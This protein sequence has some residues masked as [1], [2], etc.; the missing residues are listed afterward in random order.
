MNQHFL[1]I[2]QR[3]F[4]QHCRHPRRHSYQHLR[5]R[6]S[7]GVRDSKPSPQ[8][9]H[10]Q[11]SYVAIA[12]LTI[13]GVVGQILCPSD[14]ALATSCDDV[15]FIF[16]RGSG[17]ALSDVS[18]NAWHSALERQVSRLALKYSF[19]ELGSSAHGGYQYP[20]VSVSN[21]LGGIMTLAGAYVS[22]GSAFDFGA[23]VDQG[24]NELKSYLTEVSRACPTTKFVLGGY[25]QGAMLISRSLAELD[26]ERIIYVATFGDPKIYLPE[27]EAFTY[28]VVPKVPDACYG[29]NLSPYRAHVPD[30]Y[31]Y[32]GVLGSYRPYQPA[33]YAGK[34]GTWCNDKD[35]MCSS[36]VSLSDH[37]SY[38]ATDLYSSAAHTIAQKLRRAFGLTSTPA[39]TARPQHDIAILIDSTGSMSSYIEHYKSEAKRLATRV[40]NEGGR[41]ALFEYRDLS[42]G[43]PTRQLCDFSCDLKTLSTKLDQIT[44]SGGGDQPESVL[45]AV[46]T[47]LDSLDWLSGATKSIIILTDAGYHNPDH[48]GRTLDEV[49]DYSLSIDPV[50]VYV[51]TSATQAI[52]YQELVERTNGRT[53]DI[54]EELTL[55]TDTILG[56][57]YAKLA[58][59]EYYGAPD[60]EFIFDASGSYA[61]DDSELRFDWDLDGDGIFE[62]EDQP[63]AIRKT[64]RTE[65]NGFIQVKVTDRSGDF[66]TM[67]ARTVVSASNTPA[68]PVVSSLKLTELSPTS[69]HL[70][71]ETDAERLL[72]AV[73]DAIIGFI[74]PSADLAITDLSAGSTVSLIPYSAAGL[75]GRSASAQFG[76]SEE[77]PESS[78]VLNVLPK[79]P[80]T[81]TRFSAP[82][83]RRY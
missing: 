73:N 77:V 79:A 54:H 81:G 44:V 12:I 17:E 49:V 6:S 45:S 59:A 21:G 62:L 47:T 32:E 53:F 78:S 34:V 67:S 56:R 15:Q 8:T 28:G 70:H 60:D 18:F 76:T 29:Q 4:P 20:A 64:Y 42:D 69:A 9:L 66:A 35:I 1:A 57:P 74:K 13:F 24:A 25:S 68:L 63:S 61:L 3:F 11:L 37:T 39:S 58:L 14:S 27:G 10:S 72:L 31:A 19:Y 33:N 55:S 80:N 16:A 50:N 65:F 48:D 23:S 82:K 26:A 22:G 75:R 40:L 46:Y 71:F 30:C 51:M 41:V 43:F 2:F 38:V 52:N 36:G 5:W 7:R 83:R